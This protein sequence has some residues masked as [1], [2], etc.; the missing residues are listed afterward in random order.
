MINESPKEDLGDGGIIMDN[1]I[2]LQNTNIMAS[3]QQ[4][5]DNNAAGKAIM[6]NTIV[7]N[8]QSSEGSETQEFV[9]ATQVVDLVLETQVD[10]IRSEAVRKFLGESWDNMNG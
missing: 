2:V 1:V 8:S 7:V 5:I 6:A 9:D 3:P 10:Q 4:V